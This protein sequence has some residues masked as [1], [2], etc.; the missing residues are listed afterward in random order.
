MLADEINNV[1]GE[2][3]ITIDMKGL[4]IAFSKRYSNTNWKIKHKKPN[5]SESESDSED[6]NISY[7]IKK[8]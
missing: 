7:K 5:E 2:D 3:P 8:N 1:L 6:E 4:N